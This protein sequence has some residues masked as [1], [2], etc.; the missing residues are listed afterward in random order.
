MTLSA[1]IPVEDAGARVHR[2][3]AGIGLK[4]E[5]WDGWKYIGIKER[6]QFSIS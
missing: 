4:E 2:S 6:A 5:D 1:G 3:G